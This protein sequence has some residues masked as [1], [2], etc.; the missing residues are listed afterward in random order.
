MTRI[1]GETQEQ[2]TRVPAELLEAAIQ[3]QQAVADAVSQYGNGGSDAELR[4]RIREII[5]A[6][7]P[8]EPESTGPR[9]LGE[10]S[11]VSL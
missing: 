3:D 6:G 8:S 9:E 2:A 7:T 5:D 11:D 4:A 10:G 1:Q